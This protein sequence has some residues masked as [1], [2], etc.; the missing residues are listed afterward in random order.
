MLAG[1]RSRLQRERE[2]RL[3]LSWETAALSVAAQAGKLDPLDQ[4]LAK[5]RPRKPRTAQEIALMF[6]DLAAGGADVTI[7]R[8]TKPKIPAEEG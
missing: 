3:V 1:V 4:Y 6:A 2:D 8:H 5:I 7:T